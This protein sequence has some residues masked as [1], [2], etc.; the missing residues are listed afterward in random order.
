MAEPAMIFDALS[1]RAESLGLAVR[2]AFHPE[3]QEFDQLLP[4]APV[5]T[6]VLLGFTGGVQWDLYRC[7]AEASDG[8][9][10]PLDRWS[11]RVIGALASELGGAGLYPN[12]PPPQLPFQRLAARSEPVHQSPIGL[13]IHPEWGLWHAY[14]GALA[15][16]GR[17]ELPTPVPS[18][19]PCAGCA[20][21]PCLTSCPVKA[22]GS[23]SFDVE[24]CVDF[25]LSAAGSDCRERGCRA[26]RA[27][28]VG[29]LYRYGPDQ[30]QFHMRAFLRSVR[31]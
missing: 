1:R 10:H 26:R 13:L 18:V 15:L 27:C 22:F 6:I 8:L 2:G 30:A 14:R 3:P 16:P 21:K 20:V 24:A 19:H 5:G 31:D 17:I 23:G 4:A 28:P 12:G 25:V 7:S 11:R 29:S 9:P